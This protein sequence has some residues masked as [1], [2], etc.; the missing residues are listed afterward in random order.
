MKYYHEKIGPNREIRIPE[1]YMKSLGIYP[2]EEVELKLSG[3][4]LLIEPIRKRE[5]SQKHSR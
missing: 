2:G 1:D 3:K 5:G 4:R